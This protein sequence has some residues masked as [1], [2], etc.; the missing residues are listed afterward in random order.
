M[1]GSNLNSGNKDSVPQLLIISDIP[2]ALESPG[3]YLEDAVPAIMK[4][5]GKS[6]FEVL[7]LLFQELIIS[8]VLPN[9]S[10]SLNYQIFW[11]SK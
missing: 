8:K 2:T 9:L 1:K 3:I 5:D 7:Q 10:L 6:G 4:P 11:Y